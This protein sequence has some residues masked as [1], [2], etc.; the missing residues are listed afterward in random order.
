MLFAHQPIY[1]LAEARKVDAM[2]EL[3]LH[4]HPEE[5]IPNEPEQLHNEHERPPISANIFNG[6]F[7]L[8]VQSAF[9]S[10]YISHSEFKHRFH[11]SRFYML[12]NSLPLTVIND[13]SFILPL[14]SIKL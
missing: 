11:L 14:W 3:N 6:L 12:V 5:Y 9:H 8:I 13:F 10:Y 1:S 4:S 7:D 2:Q